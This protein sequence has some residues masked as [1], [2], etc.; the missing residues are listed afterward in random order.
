MAGVIQGLLIKVKIF[1]LAFNFREGLIA[2]IPNYLK[3]AIKGGLRVIFKVQF[4][5]SFYILVLFFRL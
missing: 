4:L 2:G 5:G 3:K 1:W